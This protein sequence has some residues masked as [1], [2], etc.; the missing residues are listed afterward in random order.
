M[1]DF[2]EIGVPVGADLVWRQRS[3]EEWIRRVL[4]YQAEGVD[5]LLTG[6]S[7]LGEVLACPSAVELDGIA[8]CLVDVDDRERWERLERRDP[9]RW[10]TDAKRAFIGWAR[11]NCGHAAD[12]RH[13][14]EAITTGAWKQMRWSRWNT[15][16][17]DDP[18]WA[19]HV[20]DTT[21]RTVEQSAAD[22]R[23]WIRGVRAGFAEGQLPLGAGKWA[24]TRRR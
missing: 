20:V 10:S 11:W 4:R 14:P 13:L 1:H 12:P 24:D 16:S 3:T 7:P 2:D 15:W 23:Q 22:L 21:R 19:V 18:R 6:Q 9:G 8:A 5:V 17:G